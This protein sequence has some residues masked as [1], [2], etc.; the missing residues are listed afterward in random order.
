MSLSA[1]RTALAWHCTSVWLRKTSKGSDAPP[2]KRRKLPSSF[3]TPPVLAPIP[4]ASKKAR[5]SEASAINRAAAGEE[6][7][8]C[9]GSSSGAPS[10]PRRSRAK[11]AAGASAVPRP[12]TAYQCFLQQTGSAPGRNGWKELTFEERRPFEAAAL[13]DRARYEADLR[14]AAE[15]AAR[16]AGTRPAASAADERD[17]L[18]SVASLHLAGQ[19]QQF[20]VPMSWQPL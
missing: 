10:K 1:L 3:T 4:Q 18:E 11:S 8:E 16:Q 14:A 6:P 15:E 12:R 9:P 13:A 5:V 7:V 17:R 20:L 2:Q 19:T